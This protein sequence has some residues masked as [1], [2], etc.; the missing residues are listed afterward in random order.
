MFIPR[1]LPVPKKPENT[2]ISIFVD[3]IHRHRKGHGLDRTIFRLCL[4]PIC[5]KPMVYEA[6][7]PIR[8]MRIAVRVSRPLTLNNTFADRETLFYILTLYAKG[9]FSSYLYS[10]PEVKQKAFRKTESFYKHVFCRS[11]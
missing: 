4:S 11:L 3:H 10:K 5:L 9:Q 2:A 8:P 6:L 7:P 1:R